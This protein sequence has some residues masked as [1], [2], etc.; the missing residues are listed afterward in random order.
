MTH[1]DLHLRG[2]IPG[3]GAEHA[4]DVPV[5]ALVIRGAAVSARLPRVAPLVQLEHVHGLSVRGARQEGATR[6][7]RER[8]DAGCALET[9]PELVELAAVPCV[10]HPDDGAL[11]AGRGDPGVGPREL[12]RCQLALVSWDDDPT[13]QSLSIEDLRRRGNHVKF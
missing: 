3:A 7:E 5:P 12:E 10:E 13:R 6:G 11:E 4:V 1:A 8:E 9:S 2:Q